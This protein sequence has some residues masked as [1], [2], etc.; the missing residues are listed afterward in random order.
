MVKL[1]AVI[2]LMVLVRA[3]LPRM[4]YD[5]LMNFGW[6]VLIPV[7]LLWVMTTGAI[8]VLPERYG[9][10]ARRSSSRSGCRGRGRAAGLGRAAGARTASPRSGEEEAA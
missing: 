3:T 1:T 8:I 6:K 7:G 2:Y 5:R 9:R 10:S 4:R